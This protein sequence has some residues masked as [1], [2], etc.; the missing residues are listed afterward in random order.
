MLTANQANEI[1]TWSIYSTTI[2]TSIFLVLSLFNMDFKIIAS[3][4]YL[5]YVLGAIIGWIFY[6]VVTKRIFHNL[7]L[8]VPESINV[9]L[10]EVLKFGTVFIISRVVIGGLNNEN[11]FDLQWIKYFTLTMIG[12]FIFEFMLQK[13]TGKLSVLEPK[14]NIKIIDII[15]HVFVFMLVELA[16]KQTNFIKDGSHKYLVGLLVGLIIYHFQISKMII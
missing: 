4:K 1:S 9:P 15:R 7:F 12:Y 6:L 3:K 14:T 10:A 13:S 16:M 5:V 11:V 8:P 2:I